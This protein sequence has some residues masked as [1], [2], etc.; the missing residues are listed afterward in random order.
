MVCE[1]PQV[2]C[3]MAV[4]N[5]ACWPRNAAFPACTSR[6]QWGSATS[7]ERTPLACL[8]K[9]ACQIA[10]DSLTIYTVGGSLSYNWFSSTQ[11]DN[12]AKVSG[13]AQCC[14]ACQ[15]EDALKEKE[16]GRWHCSGGSIMVSDEIHH[17]VFTVP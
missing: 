8:Q 13:S 16:L 7:S 3:V 2:T 10:V 14:Q 4:Q 5:F 15:A 12:E 11:V 6:E 9:A 1:G 17:H